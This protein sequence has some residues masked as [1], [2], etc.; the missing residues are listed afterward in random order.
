MPLPD[1]STSFIGLA[2]LVLLL[3]MKHGFDAD[4]LAAIDGITR[5]NARERPS[6]ARRAGALFSAGHGLVVFAVALGVSALAGSARVPGWF[7]AVGAWVS[8]GVLTGLAAVNIRAAFVAPRHAAS[9]AVGWRTGLFEKFLA[10]LLGVG[11][12]WRVMG[13]GG[14]FALSFDTLTQASLF[15]A[16]ST[17]FG[18]WESAVL[19]AGLFVLGML[20]TDGLNGLWIAGL[21]RRSDHTA[22]LASRITT[23]GVGGVS[24][25]TAAIGV[26]GQTSGAAGLWASGKELWLG[27][28]VVAIVLASFLIGMWLARPAAPARASGPAITQSTERGQLT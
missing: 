19:L 9:H 22:V 23:L 14:L 7:D 8:I 1:P 12:A 2:A 16:A 17:R 6:L 21:I 20:V 25:L 27:A 11:S 28:A 24:L 18:G 26:A 5:L 4:H 13:V 10:R 3:G 15:A